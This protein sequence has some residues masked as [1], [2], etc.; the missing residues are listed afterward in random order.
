MID[1]HWVRRGLVLSQAA[2]LLLVLLLLPGIACTQDYDSLVTM[3]RNPDPSMQN[4]AKEMLARSI[5]KSLL[6]MD[7]EKFTE[8]TFQFGNFVNPG[9]PDLAVGIS[10]PPGWGYL[11][12]LTKRD[13]HY[14]AAGP[15]IEVGLV[16]AVKSIKLF[17]CPLNQLVLN[18]YGQGSNVRQWGQ[19]IYRWDGTAMRKIWTWVRK[20][21]E[22]SW[23]L[24]PNGETAGEVTRSQIFI[25]DSAGG[26]AKEIVTSSEVDEGVFSDEKGWSTELGKVTSHRETRV[27]HKWDESLFYYVAKSGKILSP[28]ITVSCSRRMNGSESL[29][30]LY[31]GMKVGILEIPGTALSK[32]QAYYAVVGKEHF[33]KIPKSAV[34]VDQ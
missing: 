20:S 23:L 1:L 11:V 29:G 21:V 17:P 5:K 2:I 30:T 15:V 12:I 31:A 8:D 18:D 24:E 19:D 27:T 28:E 10:I 9:I 3:L 13:G 33:C 7:P 16:Q 4:K 26:E 22:S 34:R 25:N 32:G 14:M 6:S